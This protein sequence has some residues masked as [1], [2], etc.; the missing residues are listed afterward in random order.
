MQ[1]FDN[2]KLKTK[3]LFGFFAVALV[4]AAIGFWGIQNM[5][6]I[7]EMDAELYE[8]N[9]V[10]ISQMADA[11]VAFQRARINLLEAAVEKDAAAR[12][13]HIDKVKD[14][15]KSM[16][17]SLGKFEK[18]IKSEE[19][20]KD[21]SKIRDLDKQ[22]ADI[23][24]RASSL[25]ASG[26]GEQALA[27]IRSENTVKV[28]LEINDAMDKIQDIKVAQAKTKSDNNSATASSASKLMIALI[29]IGVLIS[30]SLGLFINALVQKQLGWEPDLVAGLARK[31]AAGDLNIEMDTKGK[32]GNSVIIAM[33]KMVVAIRG[34][35]ADAGMLSQAAVQGKLATRADATKHQGEYRKIVEGVNAT[36]DAM[37][38]PINVTAEYVDRI[39][40]GDIPPKITDTYNGD[41]N[42]IKNNLN[43]CIDTMTGLLAETDKLVKAT[44]DGKLATRGDAAKFAGGWGTLVGGVNNLCDAFVGPINVT[45]EYVD[46]ITKGDIP[47]KIT[48]TYNGDFNEIKNNLNAC[49]DTMSGLLAETDKLVQ[50]TVAGKLATRG[51]AAKFAGGWGK[52]VGG[53][54]NL[55]DAFVGPINVTAEYVDRITKGDIPPKITDTYNGDFNEIKNNLNACIDT[56][57]GLL[58]ET[59]KLVQATVEGKLATRGDAAKFAGG[60]GKLVGGVNNL[61]DAF[62][63]PI[64]VTAEYVDRITKGD[65]PPKITDTYNGDFNEIK[66]NLNACID[67]MNGLL[68]ETDKLVKAT[69]EGKLA[70]RGDAAKFAGGWGKLVGG[71]NNLCDAF[72]GP[73]NVTAEYVDRIT[74]GDIPPKI[75]D[76]YNGDFNE[77]KNNLNA[78]IDT[79][80]GL[81]AETDKLVQ[82]TVAGQAGDPRRRGQVR[83]RLGQAGRR[84][85]QPVRRLRRADQRDRRVCG[86]DQQGRHP[87]E[88]HRHL[89]RRLQRDQEQPERLHRYHERPAGRDGQARQGCSGRRAGY[90]ARMPRCSSAAGRS[91]YPASTTRSPIS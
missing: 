73:I 18:T 9:T 3:L 31:V 11:Q 22:F 48:D 32:D 2:M 15:E 23:G 68:A 77:I 49:I 67:T 44:V 61:C 21:F 66:N 28:A 70:T 52:L 88:D 34:L 14:L 50:A 72:V 87:A 38:G 41:F 75:T 82:A 62:V 5:H 80:S 39:S 81:L 30:I 86:P 27:L 57:S 33:E 24:A 43:A 59:D 83:G 60:W 69:V 79:M 85:Q 78:C 54:N 26:Q 10:P 6:K 58:A 71:V 13:R 40:K 90:S 37:V 8:V 53:V 25:A 63:G 36:L 19:V 45:A 20:K 4:A 56:M 91:W 42:E 1:W 65:I 12:G 46:R 55:C 35:V 17:E 76:T 74:K 51:D 84:R 16:D 89:Q 29:I 64:N 47:P 7:D